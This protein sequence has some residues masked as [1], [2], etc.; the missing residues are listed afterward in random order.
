MEFAKWFMENDAASM[1]PDARQFSYI[2]C[3]LDQMS[4]NHLEGVVKKWA[5]EQMGH[6]IPPDW[7]WRAHH[8]TVMFRQGGLT[9]QDLETYRAFFGQDV[10]L[11]VN[12]LAADDNCIAVVVK[13]DPSF[14]M[15]N[16]I[17]HITVAHSKSVS[18]VYS[19]TL[20]MD[21][22]KIHPVSSVELTSVFAAVKKD[23]HSIW[24]EKSFPLAVNSRI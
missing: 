18:P 6:G 8:M 19:N 11:H 4:Q 14:P 7:I 3:V 13:P 20:L 9:T 17:P 21:R 1:M 10:K 5:M 2:G 16:K 23:Q 15:Q 22:N 24:P 12:G